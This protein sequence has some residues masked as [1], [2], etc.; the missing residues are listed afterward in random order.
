MALNGLLARIPDTCPR[1]LVRLA[2]IARPR[3]PSYLVVDIQVHI[4]TLESTREGLKTREPINL[5]VGSHNRVVLVRPDRRPPLA[6]NPG[7][8]Q[9][10]SCFPN[11]GVLSVC[12]IAAA[13]NAVNL[14]LGLSPTSIFQIFGHAEPAGD[15]AHNKELSDKRAAAFRACLVGDF[16]ALQALGDAEGWGTTEAQVMLRTLKCDPGPI[17]GKAEKL[18]GHAARLF[19]YEYLSGVFHRHLPDVSPAEEVDPNGELDDAT[20]RALV[21]SYVLA[22]SPHLAQEQLHPSHPVAGCSEYNLRDP[23]DPSS[24]RRVTLLVH[25]SLPPHHSAAP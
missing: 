7:T 8:F 2:R 17:D 12:M 21:E 22:T 24:N 11:P 18:T 14:V 23:E 6:V 13:Q 9:H 20:R 19:Q 10:D 3:R 25:P 5:Q 1:H 15:E 16:E 4:D